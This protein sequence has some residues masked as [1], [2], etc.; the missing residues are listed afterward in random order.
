M[1]FDEARG[2]GHGGLLRQAKD[3]D[4]GAAARLSGTMPA[5]DKCAN[6]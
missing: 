3:A 4:N 1:P 5:I 6:V 2:L